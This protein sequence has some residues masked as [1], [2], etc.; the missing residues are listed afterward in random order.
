M[1][2]TVRI[3]RD[4]TGAWLARV[5][6][7]PGCHTYG[8]SLRQA[9]RRIREALSLW[10][11]DADRAD[12]SFDIRLPRDTGRAVAT[13]RSV[14][15]AADRAQREAMEATKR[16][17]ADLTGSFGLS[18][19]DTAELLELSHQRV[20]QLLGAEGEGPAGGQA[21]GKSQTS[22]VKSRASRKVLRGRRVPALPAEEPPGSPG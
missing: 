1:K 5:P 18:V 9:K 2:Y 12:L 21:K 7:V 6:E 3:E 11:T 19:R 20:Q 14:R 16:A 8:R 17:A 22:K 13:A 10:V 4:E 15:K